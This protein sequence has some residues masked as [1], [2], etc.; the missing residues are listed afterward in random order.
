MGIVTVSA[1]ERVAGGDDEGLDQVAG[2]LGGDEKKLP[3]W[4]VGRRYDVRAKR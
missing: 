4:E 3:K 1:V 2:L